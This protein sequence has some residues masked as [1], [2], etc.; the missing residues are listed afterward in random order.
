MKKIKA[1]IFAIVGV[2]VLSNCVMGVG[3]ARLMPFP[4]Y[5]LWAKVLREYVDDQGRVDY[6]KLQKNRADLDGFVEQVRNANILEMS[7]SEQKAFWINAY[8]AI[9]LKTVID[10][11]PVKSIRYINFGLVWKMPKQV[12]HVERSLGDIEHKILRP[13][14]D[15]RVH[16]ALNCASIGCPNLPDKPFYP[17]Q[18][19]K[20][21]DDETRRFMNDPEKV[22]LDRATNTLYHSELLNW[23]EDDF[24]VV[25]EDKLS[26]IKTYLNEEDRAY[27]DAHKVTLRKI[28]YDWG[29]NNKLKVRSEK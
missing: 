27:L 2:F 11:Y 17:H 1:A 13:L 20:Q 12:A 8:N 6:E 24:L 3:E 18:L 29:L 28:K 25:A 21:L 7:D 14:G 4:G 19:D 10:H 15:P 22:R 23:Y 16:F 5:E 26:Y 9:T